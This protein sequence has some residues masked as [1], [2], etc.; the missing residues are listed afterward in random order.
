MDRVS[1][2][3]LVGATREAV[4]GTIAQVVVRAACFPARHAALP[5]RF[6]YVRARAFAWRHIIR[7]LRSTRTRAMSASQ[8]GDAMQDLIWIGVLAGLMLLALLYTSLAD[9]V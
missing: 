5:L 9:K 2:T 6:A 8:E 1:L 4:F 7:P 3:G